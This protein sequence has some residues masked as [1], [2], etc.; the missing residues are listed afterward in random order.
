MTSALIFIPVKC[1]NQ[2]TVFKPKCIGRIAGR[3]LDRNEPGH[4]GLWI[5]SEVVPFIIFFTSG[6]IFSSPVSVALPVKLCCVAIRAVEGL[7]PVN[8]QSQML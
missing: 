6:S 3:E 5:L 8:F 1:F 7:V 2:N 4:V